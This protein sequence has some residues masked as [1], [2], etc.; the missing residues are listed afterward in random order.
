MSIKY[1]PWVFCC[2][3][4]LLRWRWWQILLTG[5]GNCG[6]MCED[7]L[8]LHIGFCKD[9]QK[10]CMLN[11]AEADIYLLG[12]VQSGVLKWSLYLLWSYIFVRAVRYPFIMKYCN[13]QQKFKIKSSMGPS[14]ICFKSPE[15]AWSWSK[16]VR[17]L[18]FVIEENR[19][20]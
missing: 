7:V 2:A 6:N 16:I 9:V 3:I 19:C 20:L 5:T 12:L 8:H 10:Q 18:F 13:A 11:S 4:S 14:F 15:I 17:Q 1:P